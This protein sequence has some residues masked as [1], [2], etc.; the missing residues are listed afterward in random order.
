MLSIIIS[1][2]FFGMMIAS[3]II[4]FKT[5]KLINLLDT[6]NIQIR[7]WSRGVAIKDL[8]NVINSNNDTE[9]KSMSLQTIYL[10]KL[11]TR[12]FYGSIII[13]ILIFILNVTFNWK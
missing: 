9:I 5:Y 11:S 1:I 10:L 8:K 13:I 12:I 2:I 7:R 3:A 6:K 4:F